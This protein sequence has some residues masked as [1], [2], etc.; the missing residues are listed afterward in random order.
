MT[1]KV[2]NKAS[3]L[4]CMQ[5]RA[6]PLYVRGCTGNIGVAWLNVRT[7]DP[8]LIYSMTVPLGGVRHKL[9]M[10]S[11]PVINLGLAENPNALAC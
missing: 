2:V 7:R 3:A 11:I 6:C 10:L 4:R 8:L 9:I 5:L 1:L